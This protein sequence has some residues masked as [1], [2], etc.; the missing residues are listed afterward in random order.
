MLTGLGPIVV[1]AVL[2]ASSSQAIASRPSE[3]S[4]NPPK[5]A[6]ADAAPVTGESPDES[7]LRAADAELSTRVL[8]RLKE[9][10]YLT[11][12]CIAIGASEGS[13]RIQGLTRHKKDVVA[14]GRLVAAERGVT[15]VIN[16]LQIGTCPS[17]NR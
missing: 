3:P 13:I 11:G 16:H 9:R 10:G 7:A 5:T 15:R 2:A 1:V 6:A 4:G 12:N 14:I 8:A 17:P